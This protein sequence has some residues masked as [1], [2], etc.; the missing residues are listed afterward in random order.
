MQRASTYLVQAGTATGVLC[1]LVLAVLPSE[2]P[3]PFWGTFAL[4]LFSVSMF[5][6][7]GAFAAWLMKR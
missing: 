5:C 2:G 3:N 1:L 7:L 4:V 6:W